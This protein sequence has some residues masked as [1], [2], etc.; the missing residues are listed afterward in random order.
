MAL[1]EPDQ[2]FLVVRTN[3]RLWVLMLFSRTWLR[4]RSALA[5][6]IEHALYGFWLFTV[7]LGSYFA[8]SG[9]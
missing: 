8:F 9:S 5:V 6:S 3:P 4:S 2:L 7:G 1:L